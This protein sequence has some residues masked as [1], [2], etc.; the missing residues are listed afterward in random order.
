MESPTS[1]ATQGGTSDT[2]TTVGGGSATFGA[3]GVL[4]VGGTGSYSRAGSSSTAETI[5]RGRGGMAQVANE[6]GNSDYV[7]FVDDFHYM[8][9]ELQSEVAKQLKAAAELGI[10]SCVAT[11]PHRSDDM[12]R[13]NP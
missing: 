7:L 13:A 1:R 2:T 6:I 12:V 4:T 9:R 11:V 5:V 3:P 10:K 8:P